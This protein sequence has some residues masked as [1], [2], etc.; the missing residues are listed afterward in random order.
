MNDIVLMKAVHVEVVTVI[1]KIF[2]PHINQ[3]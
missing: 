3:I 1:Y 2:T